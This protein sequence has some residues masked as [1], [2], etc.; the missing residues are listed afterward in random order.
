MFFGQYLSFRVGM[1]VSP[2]G[3]RRNEPPGPFWCSPHFELFF[4]SI[5]RRRISLA[6]SLVSLKTG[7]VGPAASGAFFLT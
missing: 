3:G 4:L 1:V 5:I 7:L 2:L 6:A